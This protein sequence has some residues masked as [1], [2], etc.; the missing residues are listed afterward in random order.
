[1]AQDHAALL[2]DPRRCR[3]PLRGHRRQVHRRRDHGRLR[4]PGRP[5]GPRA[6]RLLRGAADARGRLRVRRRAAPRARA[7]LLGPDRDQLRRGRRR[8]D[9]RGRR[10]QL[11][12]D[13]PYRRAGAADG[14]AGRAGQG[15][16]DRA[17]GGA[18]RRLP[19]ARGPRRV[20]DQGGEPPRP[21]LRAGRRRRCPLAARPLPRTRLL[22]L[23]RAGGGDRGAA[24]RPGPRAGGRRLRDRPRRRAGSR[25]EPPLP[26][27]RRALPRRRGRGLRGAGAG[28]RTVDPV[29]AGAADAALLLPHRRAGGRAAGAGEDRRPLAAARPRASARTCR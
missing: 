10:K 27:V 22:A 20:R 26:R 19:R 3:D 4:G 15:L 6:P 5:R 25:Q 2:L 17:R 14:G 1:M 23:R 9:R 24:G 18:R 12:G 13:R 8:G 29:H 28:A 16:P 7:Q 21:R 11:H